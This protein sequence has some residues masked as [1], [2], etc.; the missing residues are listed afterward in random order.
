MDSEY[1][2]HGHTTCP[3]PTTT[4]GEVTIYWDTPLLTDKMLK[5]NK[6]NTVIW[7]T[8]Q[9]TAQLTESTFPQDYYVVSAISNKTTKYKYLQIEIKKCWNQKK[10]LLCRLW[11]VHSG[12]HVTALRRTWQL[13]P[14]MHKKIVQKTALLGTSHILRNLLSWIQVQVYKIYYNGFGI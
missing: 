2:S 5:F 13:S 10:L 14:T 1:A 11:L 6:P 8:T 7:N 12:L 9:R 4:K 3:Y